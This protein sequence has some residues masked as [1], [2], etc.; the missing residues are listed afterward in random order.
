VI[1]KTLLDSLLKRSAAT[2]RLSN[3]QHLSQVCRQQWR[4]L[5]LGATCHPPAALRARFR[6]DLTSRLPEPERAIG[7]GEPR[8]HIGPAPLSAQVARQLDRPLVLDRYERRALS[9][10]K[11]LIR[12][13]DQ[14]SAAT[15][16][17][18]LQQS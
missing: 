18:E 4:G 14:A 11:F 2:T 12:A 8:R 7:D 6:P 1:R 15:V 5:E 16:R 17:K 10:R 9:R 13:F 3:S